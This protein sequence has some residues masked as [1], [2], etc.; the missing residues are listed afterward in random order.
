MMNNVVELT[1]PKN[2]PSHIDLKTLSLDAAIELERLILG[3][4]GDKAVIRKLT[5]IFLHNSDSDTTR[6]SHGL[7]N[8]PLKIEICRRAIGTSPGVAVRTI[9][10]L[11][12]RIG[13]I[14]S[15]VD[16]ERDDGSKNSLAN[17][18]DFCLALH[19]ELLAERSSIR[20]EEAIPHASR[21]ERVKFS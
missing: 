16:V 12:Q 17:L 21:T 7:Y 5:E 3:Q 10:E 19:R 1:N 2:R 8:N 4:G 14:V 15:D 13:K 6:L 9:D 20:S 18:R 11:K